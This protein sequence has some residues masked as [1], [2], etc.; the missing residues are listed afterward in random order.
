MITGSP[1]KAGKAA[2]PLNFA[3]YCH[4]AH[5]S[6]TSSLEDRKRDSLSWSIS[7]RACRDAV[8]CRESLHNPCQDFILLRIMG[9]INGF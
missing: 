7:E 1:V 9:W 4:I 5:P 2:A 8:K 6:E 3:F